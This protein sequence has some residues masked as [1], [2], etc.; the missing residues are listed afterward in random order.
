[1]SEEKKNSSRHYEGECPGCGHR[2]LSSTSSC[3]QC[4]SLSKGGGGEITKKIVDDSD[5]RKRV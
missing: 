1:M 2:W 4:G 5:L 3:P